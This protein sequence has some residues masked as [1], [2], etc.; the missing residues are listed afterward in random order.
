MAQPVNPIDSDTDAAGTPTLM[1]RLNAEALGTFVLVFVGVGTLLFASGFPG[2]G[3]V[4]L[5]VA[6]AF[7][8]TVL[9]GAFAFGHV[10]GAYFN[11]ALTVGAALAG[12]ISWRDTIGYIIAQLVGGIVG[13]ALLL[14]IAAGGP[15]GFLAKAQES[16]FGSTGYGDRSP[17]GFDL[18]SVLL[19]EII[20]TAV[21][22]YVVLG[23]TDRRASAALAPIAIGLTLTMILLVAL[24]V[25]GASVNP[26]RSIATAI[27]GDGVALG[28]VW[29]FIV[30][31][32]V[33]GAIAGLTY[34]P[35]FD[36]NR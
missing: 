30:A 24:P 11:P 29:V 32:I 25:S 27:F 23:A 22:M 4:F 2:A 16:G 1:S 6:L 9:A 18:L 34:R 3:E 13:A 28:Q 35:L 5:P 36:R 8:L 12:R 17:A 20:L 26:A 10:S 33:G 19:I 21:F 7:G 14:A 31:P 15:D